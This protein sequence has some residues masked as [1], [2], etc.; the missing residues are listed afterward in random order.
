VSTPTAVKR[1][2]PWAI[3]I[4]IATGCLAAVTTAVA[5]KPIAPCPGGRF[6]VTGE[7]VITPAVAAPDTI[8]LGSTVSIGSGCPPVEVKLKGSKRGTTVK[9]V[10]RSGCTGLSGKI[11]LGGRIDKTCTTLTGMVRG[12]KAK[13]RRRFS[14][15]R[16]TCGDGLTDATT[17]TCDGS[18][19]CPGNRICNATCTGCIASGPNTPP[20]ASFTVAATGTAGTPLVFD[21]RASTDPDGDPLTHSFDFGDGVRGGG[22]Q[23]A[24][25]FH[26][27]GT[28]TVRLTVGDDRGGVDTADAD[29]TI[30]EGPAPGSEVTAQG[31][32]RAVDGTP[33]AG[34]MVTVEPGGAN[35]QT[36]ASGRVAV[37]VRKDVPTQIHVRKSGFADQIVGTSIPDG[38]ESAIFEATLLPRETPLSLADA[39]AGGALVGTHGAR[40][41]IPPNAVVDATG[42]AV[43]GPIDVSVTPLDVTAAPRAFPGRCR[44]VLPDGTE[45]VIITYGTVEYV[46]EQNGNRLNLKP[47]SAAT[48]DI[49]VYA[50]LKKDRTTVK[51]GDTF[52]LWSLD[53]RTGNWVAEA[54]GTVVASDTSPTGLVL[55]GQVTHFTWWNHDDFDFPPALPEPKCLVD[56]NADGVLEDLTGTGHCW[57][58]GTGPEQPD[59]GFFAPTSAFNLRGRGTPVR[60]PRVPQ[61]TAQIEL[62]AA[63]GVPVPIP[64]DMDILFHSQAKNGTLAGSKLVR[65]GPNVNQ[66]IVVVLEPVQ[67]NPGTIAVPSLPYDSRFVLGAA[68]EIDRYTFAAE[69]NANYEIRVSRSISSLL[70]GDVRVLNAGGTILVNA[71]FADNA[72]AR[73]LT[74]T[75]AGTLTIEVQARANTPGGYH[76]EIR[77]LSS[78]ACAALVLPSTGN[79]PISGNGTKC[80]D[81]TLAAGAAISIVNT[82]QIDARGT[83][84]LST[85]EGTE[86]ATDTYGSGVFD[87][88]GL[89]LAV[90]QAGTYRLVIVNSA[91]TNGTLNGLTAAPLPLAGSLAV[92]SSV[93]FTD[94]Q[95]GGSNN[96]YYLVQPGS[97]ATIATQ[98]AAN[99]INQGVTIYPENLTFTTPTIEARIVAPHPAVLPIVRVF[100]AGGGTGW[101]YTLSVAEP[102][103]LPL[104]T[105]VDLLTPGPEQL[106][107][108]RIDGTVGN[109][110]SIGKSRAPNASINLVSD[111]YAPLTGTRSAAPLIHTLATSGPHTLTVRSSS[112]AGGAF[113]LRVNQLS[114][115]EPITLDTLTTR[116]GVLALGE[117]KRYAFD[118]IQAQ[119][120]TLQLSSPAQLTAGANATGAADR[121]GGVALTAGPGGGSN[122]TAARYV[123]QTGAAGLQVYSDSSQNDRA[124]GAFQVGIQRPTPTPT[125]LGTAINYQATPNVLRT[126]SYDITTPGP[127]LLCRSIDPPGGGSTDFVGIVWGPSAPFANYDFGDLNG[128]GAGTPVES[129]GT[130]RTGQNTLSLLTM[131][132]GAASVSA[133]L[134]ALP[135][136]VDVTVG[137]AAANGTIAA[138]QRHYLRFAAV[139]GTS[140]TVRVTGQF[141]GVVRVRKQAPNG[142]YT[143]Q[144]DF[145][146]NLGGTPQALTAGVERTVTFTIPTTSQFGTGNY[147]ITVDAD[148]D[149][150]GGF[151]ATVTSP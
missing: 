105:D 9:A 103:T 65:L 96:R 41:V 76:I 11:V 30:A 67:G 20:D 81:L 120:L 121:V 122:A 2:I 130:L 116:N 77:K 129:I 48:I 64:A 136:L 45:G 73:V 78:G 98:L 53:E 51:V 111:L 12:R 148:G 75:A 124:T 46:L 83:V 61:F 101:Q 134:V 16:S 139:G 150:T 99:S 37:G 108:F 55:R 60:L 33:I 35:G 3:A 114:P 74:A 87:A 39:A 149:A 56:T 49:P 24:H 144:S 131:R 25:V 50:N 92:P 126:F 18:S 58:A 95:T 29:V 146:G 143:T 44:G 132:A 26:D 113:R 63:G 10:W 68:N 109:E 6:L 59:D 104:D 93:S 119:V 28:Y 54:T 52:P 34:A 13:L 79:Y 91:N 38:A 1:P 128:H 82:Q 43:T 117:V 142:S 31:L 17:E 66:E 137:G 125:A 5:R 7:P 102:P 140:Y 89:Y 118:V 151:T 147:I 85:P 57:H 110:W 127:H 62:P 135:A 27:A 123:H 145:D 90:A 47:G 15:T 97:A 100:R 115:P 133:R 42:A 141:A 40:I 36:D 107:V 138:C 14:A 71:S 112:A 21:G 32:V 72:F 94:A 23:V 69:A 80:F 88:I 86:L 106:L 70:T 8:V 19:G 84:T 22:A 4:L